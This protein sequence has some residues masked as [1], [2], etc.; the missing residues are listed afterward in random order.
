TIFQ[1]TGHL[2]E[3][4]DISQEEKEDVLR[5]FGIDFDEKVVR[6]ARTLNLIAGDGE[7]NVMHLNSLDY[8]RWSETVTNPEWLDIYGSGFKR[9]KTLIKDKESYKEFLFDILMANPPKANRMLKLDSV[10][11]ITIFV[12]E[13]G[14]VELANDLFRFQQNI[15]VSYNAVDISFPVF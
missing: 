6:V 3:N 4:A 13:F 2:F 14:C 1:L 15:F 10:F 11:R 5:V 12:N 8:D 7:T 9:L